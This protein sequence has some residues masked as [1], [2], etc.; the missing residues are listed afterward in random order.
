MR[1]LHPVAA[2]PN[3]LITDDK[4]HHSTK[5][6]AVVLLLMAGRKNKAVTVTVG[7][8]A[9]ESK[10]STA[11]VQQA[12][13]ELIEAGY[14]SKER[15]YRFCAEMNRLIYAAN[16]YLWQ[17]REGGYTLVRRD[18]LSYKVTHA[19]FCNLLFLYR[20]A[21]Q[22]DR[23]F[24]SLRRIAGF[25]RSTGRSGLD[26]AKSTVCRVLKA[27]HKIQA[28]L[29]VCYEIRKNFF[30]ANSYFLTDCVQSRSSDAFSDMGSPKFDKHNIINQLTKGYTKRKEKYGVAQFGEFTKNQPFYYDGTGVVV[31]ASEEQL[32]LLWA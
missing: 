31:S 26:M 24:P 32:E 27:L 8:L 30:G 6:V 12:I 14:I 25:F 19:A 2:V 21:G 16:S 13:R 10:C 5:R 23:A 29:R 3:E 22:K 20:C 4:L 7:Q 28:I 18:I 9:A 15:K 17:R 11:T 1:Y